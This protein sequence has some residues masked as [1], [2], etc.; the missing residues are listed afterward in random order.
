LTTRSRRQ[1]G[2]QRKRNKADIKL[3]GRQA[4]KKI[5]RWIKRQRQTGLDRKI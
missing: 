2:R 3:T 5:T 1:A 4:N